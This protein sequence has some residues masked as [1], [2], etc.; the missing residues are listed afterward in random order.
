MSAQA[1]DERAHQTGQTQEP[2]EL[3]TVH[4]VAKQLRVDD[5]SV[6]RW[7]KSGTLPAIVLPHRGKRMAYRIR[8][9]TMDAMLRSP[10]AGQ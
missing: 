1:P 10:K 3:W 6:R 9:S 4:E 5:T 7:I 2:E 8:Q